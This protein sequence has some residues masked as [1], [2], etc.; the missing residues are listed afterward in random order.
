V[1]EAGA[2]VD[3]T[4]GEVHRDAGDDQE[5]EHY[6]SEEEKFFME[7]YKNATTP[8]HL[9]CILGHDHIMHY[10][11]QKGANPSLQSSIKGY[12]CLHLA[13]LA[14]KPE[15]IIELLTNTNANAYMPDYSGRTLTDMVES[16]IPDYLQPVLSCRILNSLFNSSFSAGEFGGGTGKGRAC[17]CHALLQ[18]GRR[19]PD[20][21]LG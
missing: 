15:I 5:E 16:F 8:L 21:R 9:A 19:P 14:N 11:I 1:E 3:L 6:D 10:L 2:K 17:G 7:A 4:G 20:Q 12:S 13:V 18:P